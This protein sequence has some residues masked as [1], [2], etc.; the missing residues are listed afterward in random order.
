MIKIF[1]HFLVIITTLLTTFYSLNNNSNHYGYDFI[2]ILPLIYLIGYTFFYI[3]LNQRMNIFIVLITP[4]MYI[5]YVLMSFLL[6]YTGYDAARSSLSPLESS[7]NLAVV[8]MSFEMIAIFVV[9]YFGLSKLKF[10]Y[11]NFDIDSL[12]NTNV[13]ILFIILTLLAFLTQPELWSRISFMIP[14]DRLL[15]QENLS[16]FAS[17]TYFSMN[18]SRYLLLVIVTSKLSKL[19][20]LSG[21][22]VIIFINFFVAVLLSLIIFGHNRADFLIGF[23]AV[24][25]FMQIIYKK[26]AYI[27][28]AFFVLSSPIIVY[29]ITKSRDSISSDNNLPFLENVTTNFQAY[30]GGIYNVAIAIET[31]EAFGIENMLL[32]LLYDIF[33]PFLGLNVLFQNS[34]LTLTNHLFNYRI[35]GSD[36]VSQIMPSVGHGYF[37]FGIILS[38]IF[39]IILLLLARFLIKQIIDK[40]NIDLVFFLLI[41]IFRLSLSPA[42][43]ISIMMNDLS[44]ILVIFLPLYLFNR[45]LGTKYK[46]GVN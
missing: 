17:I 46:K 25:F 14:N 26:K 31:K 23:L 5:R 28:N 35:Y 2:W 16:S 4:I 9:V 22:P 13:Y 15:N 8:L 33:R 21:S 19:Y 24:L 45:M 20:S 12:K 29:F 44:S 3:I 39:T 1:I 36:H 37:Y 10:S 6:S 30:L 11:K 43:N 42:Q 32:N 7:Y 27:Y 40:K 18:I 34:D 41:P 38:P